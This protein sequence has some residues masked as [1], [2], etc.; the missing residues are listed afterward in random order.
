M[1]K[2]V[3]KNLA[4]HPDVIHNPVA[5]IS[6]AG[7]MREGKSFMLSLL[8]LY[9][10]SNL[11]SHWLDKPDTPIPY[12]FNWKGGIHR[13]TRGVW[14]WSKPYLVQKKNGTTIAL[15]LMYTQGCFDKSGARNDS[16]LFTFSTLLSS[17]QIYN[18][19]EQIKENHLQ[20]LAVFIDHAKE[21]MK[22]VQSMRC[23][24]TLLFLVRDW[25]G[26]D[27][28]PFGKEG[29]DKY[30]EHEVFHY[31]GNDPDI[32]MVIDQIRTAFTSTNCVLLPHPGNV[33][34][35]GKPKKPGTPICVKDMDDEFR[36]EIHHFLRILIDDFTI[37]LKVGQ[38]DIVGEELLNFTN[39]LFDLLQTNDIENPASAME[40][41]SMAKGQT[42]MQRILREYD[43]TLETAIKGKCEDSVLTRK[44]NEAKRKALQDYDKDSAALHKN[45]K[46]PYKERLEKEIKYIFLKHLDSW[47]TNPTI[48]HLQYNEKL[49]EII[50]NYERLLEEKDPSA[51]EKVN[52]DFRKFFSDKPRYHQYEEKL[53]SRMKII[54]ELKLNP[55]NSS[56]KV[57]EKEIHKRE[58]EIRGT[59]VI[60][61]LQQQYNT[62]M[63]DLGHCTEEGLKTSHEKFQSNILRNYEQLF[64]T[65]YDHLHHEL[66]MRLVE[67][68]EQSFRNYQHKSLEKEN[69]LHKK[70]EELVNKTLKNFEKDLEDGKKDA[71]ENAL[72]SFIENKPDD[73]TYHGEYYEKLVANM[74]N[75]QRH[76]E[77]QQQLKK[78]LDNCKKELGNL[79]KELRKSKEQNKKLFVDLTSNKD[80]IRQLTEKT[81]QLEDFENKKNSDATHIPLEQIWAIPGEEG[82]LGEGSFGCVRLGFTKANGAVAVKIFKVTGSGR[83]IKETHNKVMKEIRNLKLS[84]HANV[85]RLEGYT[86]WRGAAGIIMEYMPAG[87]L[88]FFLTACNNHTPGFKIPDIPA[89]IRLRICADVTSGV[90]FLHHGFTDQRITHGDLK[91]HNILL[92][93]DLRCKVGDFGGT[94]FATCTDEVHGISVGGRQEFTYCYA[95]PERLLNRTIR[96]SKAMDVYSV[97]MIYYEVLARKAPFRGSGMSRDDIVD[98]V[99]RQ[100]MRPSLDDVE[101]LKEKSSTDDE[102]IISLIEDQMKKCWSHSPEERPSMI[103]V[104]DVFERVLATKDI[105]SIMQHITN[106]TQHMDIRIPSCHQVQCVRIDEIP[107]GSAT[108]R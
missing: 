78:E 25:I 5:V 47:Q 61:H 4:E 53:K 103:D 37:P 52:E 38:K 41:I 36:E 22:K 73:D 7:A 42:L 74:K 26:E 86:T 3:L 9:L 68:L 17:V 21:S 62:S 50:R 24:Q 69:T 33:I 82:F 94:Q 70:Y 108:R 16:N 10:E 14:I 40:G 65:R 104:R 85:I 57:K 77:N 13:E 83:E 100:R 49:L 101:S 43:T 99:A 18:L 97:S 29:G 28:F 27:D 44:H 20:S 91:P 34:A 75:F 60:E 81:R 95:S 64:E 106:I 102:E 80:V 93:Y 48:L 92:T 31:E 1:D 32:T 66:R 56:L 8:T 59:R 6:I 96:T 98:H 39:N 89:D 12:N 54:E 15:L 87:D 79:E 72:T 23:F 35:K 45:H 71:K 58:E 84:N 2:A 90:A 46:E 67:M 11:D 105:P 107:T 63:D 76:F 19:K 30:L 55:F 51:K 88:H